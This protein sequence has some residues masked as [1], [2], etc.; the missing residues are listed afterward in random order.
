MMVAGIVKLDIYQG[1][2]QEILSVRAQAH[3]LEGTP[4]YTGYGGVFA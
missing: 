3:V 2:T 1:K 4:P